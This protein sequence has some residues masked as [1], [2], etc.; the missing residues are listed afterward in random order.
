VFLLNF[1]NGQFWNVKMSFRMGSPAAT[2]PVTSPQIQNHQPSSSRVASSYF[3]NQASNRNSLAPDNIESS[4]RS[5]RPSQVSNRSI[6]TN[7]SSFPAPSRSSSVTEPCDVCKKTGIKTWT[8]I[9]C[10]NDAFCDDCWGKERA[11]R[12]GAVGFDGKPHEKTDRRVVERLRH[13]LEPKRTPEEQQ[14][15]HKNDE[16]TTWF[17]I[18]RD[19]ANLPICQDYERYATIMYQSRTSEVNVRYPQLVSFI[20]QTGKT[21]QNHPTF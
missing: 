11:H 1:F 18:A 10:N 15:L 3:P 2:L 13:I 19:S 7:Q 8:C 6:Q 5:R 17:G 16:D 14:E 20:G 9:Q 12:P 4:A 21:F